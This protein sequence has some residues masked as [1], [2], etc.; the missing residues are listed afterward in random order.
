MSSFLIEKTQKRYFLLDKKGYLDELKVLAEYMTLP[1]PEE[2][3]KTLISKLRESS[4]LIDEYPCNKYHG[5]LCLSNILIDQNI[6]S[7]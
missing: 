1:S 3:Y 7:S 5:D 4:Y 2:I 6:T